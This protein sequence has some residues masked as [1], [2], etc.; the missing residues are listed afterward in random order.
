MSN[1]FYE[2]YIVG[3]PIEQDL[4]R[5]KVKKHY[6]KKYGYKNIGNHPISKLGYTIPK[7]YVNYSDGIQTLL[8]PVNI[9]TSGT[10][11][12][13][14]DIFN[15]LTVGSNIALLTEDIR[16]NMGVRGDLSK[17]VR[18][19]DTYGTACHIDGHMLSSQSF[20]FFETEGIFVYMLEKQIKGKN[21]YMYYTRYLSLEDNAVYEEVYDE[22][23]AHMYTD[24]L[25][26]YENEYNEKAYNRCEYLKS[27][28]V[29]IICHN[30]VDNSWYGYSILDVVVNDLMAFEMIQ[31]EYN[32]A[33]MYAKPRLHIVN[34]M[35]DTDEFGNTNIDLVNDVYVTTDANYTEDPSKI[36]EA[37]QFDIKSPEYHLKMQDDLNKILS[38][39]GL[40]ESVLAVSNSTTD[41]TTVEVS[42]NDNRMFSKMEARKVI[43]APQLLD[44]VNF[45]YGDVDVHFVPAQYTNFGE[46]VKQVTMLRGQGLISTERAIA[47]L[48]THESVES[49]TEEV[50]MIKE[51]NNV[52]GNRTSNDVAEPVQ[53]QQRG[54]SGDGSRGN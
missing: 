21:S 3:G 36:I 51:E 17:L 7:D 11:E 32:K 52:K 53:E 4:I 39:V 48:Y 37:V 34:D 38:K 31:D 43:Y 8:H 28:G 15:D 2:P 14:I 10:A 5:Q 49:R 23:G 44:Y 40:D 24:I 47:L 13:I 50:E 30:N 33:V 54:D 20:Y 18:I 25:E 12:M 16:I 1:V 41:K 29:S 42:S 6:K 22:K 26:V 9:S 19:A 46:M 35:V 27:I 45:I